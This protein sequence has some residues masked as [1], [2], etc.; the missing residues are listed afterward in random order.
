MAV[1]S[2]RYSMSAAQSPEEVLMVR[3]SN[4]GFNQQTAVTNHFQVASDI[5]SIYRS[6]EVDPIARCSG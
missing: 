3:P 6:V 4:F 2:R 1:S 5:I